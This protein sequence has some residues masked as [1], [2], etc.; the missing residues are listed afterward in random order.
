MTIIVTLLT[1]LFLIVIIK[2]FIY[3]EIYY[4]DD[5][6]ETDTVTTTTTTTETVIDTSN[7]PTLAREYSHSAMAYF[8]VDPVDGDIVFLQDTD[9]IYEDGADKWWKLV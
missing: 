8:V 7:M 5:L 9:D 1:I 6:V 4:Y 3:P 2:M